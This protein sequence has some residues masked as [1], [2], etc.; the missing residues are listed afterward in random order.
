MN[1]KSFRR[2]LTT[3]AYNPCSISIRFKLSLTSICI[4]IASFVLSLQFFIKSS[5]KVSDFFKNYGYI[6]SYIFLHW[7]IYTMFLFSNVLIFPIS[8]FIYSDMILFFVTNKD[9]LGWIHHHL[10][11][12]LPPSYQFWIYFRWFNHF[13]FHIINYI[14]SFKEVYGIYLF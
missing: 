9:K 5:G 6:T 1:F 8:M 2:I 12:Q 7:V 13:S 14:F 10:P 4:L 11:L 3:C